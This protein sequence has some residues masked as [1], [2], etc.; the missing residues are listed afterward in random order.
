MKD[1][2]IFYNFKQSE[3]T[4]QVHL[5]QQWNSVSWICATAFV[6]NLSI[7]QNCKFAV[8]LQVYRFVIKNLNMYRRLLPLFKTALPLLVIPA[9]LESYRAFSFWPSQKAYNRIDNRVFTAVEVSNKPCED[10]SAHK[11]L[12]SINGYA[13]G[14]F[15]GHGGWQ[16]VLLFLS[17]HT[18]AHR[19]CSKN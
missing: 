7:C 1:F 8:S 5:K 13:V 14:V 12:Q 19:S 3:P 9:S 17:S 2:S 11:Q 6:I 16:V 10:R 4:T 15:D 18:C